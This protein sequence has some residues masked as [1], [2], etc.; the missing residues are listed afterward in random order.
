MSVSVVGHKLSVTVDD[1]RPVN[2]KACILAENELF[3]QTI[4]NFI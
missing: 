1:G 3:L 2:P 4:F